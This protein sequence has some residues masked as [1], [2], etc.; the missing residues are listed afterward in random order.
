MEK[1]LRYEYH[2]PTGTLISLSSHG[3]EVRTN[4]NNALIGML[5]TLHRNQGYFTQSSNIAFDSNGIVS[6]FFKYKLA[7]FKSFFPVTS[8][9]IS[10]DTMH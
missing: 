4:R 2:F 10:R 6:V 3:E 7:F 8:L 9:T 5:S 1:S